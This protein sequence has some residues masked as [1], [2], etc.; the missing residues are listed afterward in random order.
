MANSL[1]DIFGDHIM[2]QGL[3]NLPRQPLANNENIGKVMT[4]PAKPNEP[5][6]KGET[7]KSFLSNT[8]KALQSTPMRQVFTPRPVNVGALIYNDT[9]ANDNEIN[10]EEFEF[11]KPTYKYDNFVSDMHDYL[12]LP[13][14]VIAQQVSPP[15]TPP[16]LVKHS[17]SMEYEDSYEDD[18]FR[19]DFSTM[20]ECFQDNEL[21]LP[22]LY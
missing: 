7:K 8:G 14:T 18:F 20:T 2:R 11:S 19:D 3:K 12:A 9:D 22:G 21:G 13:V 16:P 4:T 6:K 15:S 10:V 1:F 17:L 5:L